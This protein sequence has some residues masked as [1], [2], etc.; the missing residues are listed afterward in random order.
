M[1][2]HLA[3]LF[4]N[5]YG[6]C[7]LMLVSDHHRIFFEH[8]FEVLFFN[9]GFDESLQLPAIIVNITGDVR[10]VKDI[11]SPGSTI[12]GQESGFLASNRGRS[13]LEKL[14]FEFVVSGCRMFCEIK[15][16]ILLAT[17]SPIQ[18]TAHFLYCYLKCSLAST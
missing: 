2:K 14:S 8:C 13:C 1:F 10:R 3:V 15:S 17:I 5:D 12:I 7:L 16:E 4:N 6:T 9:L 11:N 18:Q